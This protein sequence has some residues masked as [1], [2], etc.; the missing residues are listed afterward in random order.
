[1]AQA[2]ER[3][4]TGSISTV[5]PAKR[6]RRLARELGVVK[7]VRKVDLVFFVQALV[8]GFCSGRERTLSGLRRAYLLLSGQNLARSSFYQRLTGGLVQLLRRLVDDALV[9]AEGVV[10][11]QGGLASFREVLAV[12]SCITMLHSSLR[13][14]FPGA[15]HP[16][17][18]KLTLIT[19]VVG[20]TP[21]SLR[22]STGRRAD[23]HLLDYEMPL[24]GRLLIFDL[25]FYSVRVFDRILQKNGNFLT[26]VRK[27]GNP[28]VV[29]SLL[30]EHRW[31]EGRML[32]EHQH[33]LKG[34][35][36]DVEVELPLM[37]RDLSKHVLRLRLVGVW[38][39]VSGCWHRYITNVP[40]SQLAKEHVSAVY[41]A[42]WEI[43]LVFRELQSDYRLS[44]LSSRKPE[45]VE[46]LLLAAIL[47]LAVSRRLHELVRK[48]LRMPASELPRDRWA[49]I[50]AAVSGQ[51]LALLAAPC[52][53]LERCLLQL[54]CSDAPDP[55]KNRPLLPQ[56]VQNGVAAFS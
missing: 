56:R 46:A 40:H 21:R 22:I 9:A 15:R 32:R 50:F 53:R 37:R 7:R 43:E 33:N 6:I 10:R 2:Q 35:F 8:L 34:D 44:Q 4:I 45:V 52:A 16:A 5:L 17:S 41:S 25:G 14:D 18:V 12:D 3:H 11:G 39:Q 49:R 31:L 38:N 54:M 51:L 36:F 30:P 20:R 29:R 13:S 47:S 48:K 55:N 26:R 28:R 23:V 42:R 24:K 1:M 27:A 19:N